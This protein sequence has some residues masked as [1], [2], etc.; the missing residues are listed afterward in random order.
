MVAKC[1]LCLEQGELQRS[2]L[3]PKALYRLIGSGTD[4][5]HPDT[6]QLSSEGIKKSSEQVWRHLLCSECEDRLNKNGEAWTLHNCYRGSGIF[7]LRDKLRKGTNLS[8]GAEVETYSAAVE[9]VTKL[10]YFC[11]SVVWRASLCDW[12]C[13][14]ETYKQ[15]ELGPY[16]EKI[17][18]YIRGRVAFQTA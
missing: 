6:V 1:R 9:A 10:S 3:L 7:R 16:Q 12:V 8:L 4:P 2:H 14:R 5:D 11:T 15:I 17:R 18:K 13:R